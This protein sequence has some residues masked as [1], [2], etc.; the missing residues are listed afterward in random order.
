MNL[1]DIES[2]LK[3]AEEGNVTHAAE[4]LFITPSALN[5]QL[6]N[7]E[8]ELE[9][10]LFIRD[11]T[12]WTPTEAGKIYLKNAK[13]IL[14]LKNETY[15]QLQDIVIQKKGT[16]CIGVPPERGTDL[17]INIYPKFHKEFPKIKIKVLE[18]NVKQQQHLIKKGELDIGFMTLIPSQRTSDEYIKISSEKLILALHNSHSLCKTIKSNC[19]SFP[20]LDLSLLKNDTFAILNKESTI[21]EV[22]SSL[23]KK[24]NISPNILFETTRSKAI[25]E[26]VAC[27]MCCGIIPS[28]FCKTFNENISYFSLNPS[29]NLDIVASYKKDSY[30]NKPAKFFIQ[31]ASDYFNNL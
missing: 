1:K 22:I 9:I 20:E 8:K 13:E 4:K 19:N 30:L 17:F 27:N 14:R 16:L 6:L 3:I 25:L 26:M 12:G 29:I 24:V 21:F 5:Q 10:Q 7:L 2:I 31:L 28:Y 11:R 15:K 23:L 18:I